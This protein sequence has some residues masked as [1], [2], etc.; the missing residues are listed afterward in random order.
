MENIFQI[1]TIEKISTEYRSKSAY[2]ESIK[3]SIFDHF[4]S[5]QI[6]EGTYS[7]KIK[8]KFHKSWY[9]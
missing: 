2:S 3:K 6:Q 9:V 8:G 4:T 1:S 5:L 7:H